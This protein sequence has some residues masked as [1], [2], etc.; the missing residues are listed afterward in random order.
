MGDIPTKKLV[1]FSKH[2]GKERERPFAQ[3]LVETK[4][5]FVVLLTRRR[6]DTNGH[7]EDADDV[8]DRDRQVEFRVEISIKS[9]LFSQIASSLFLFPSP[10][11]CR[12]VNS[13]PGRCPP[14]SASKESFSEE[15]LVAMEAP[16]L[17]SPVI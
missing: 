14:Q 7:D 11:S 2:I 5:E 3:K 1:N 8:T 12:N 17:Q 4:L 13:T 15:S 9:Q 10:N 16:T 6:E